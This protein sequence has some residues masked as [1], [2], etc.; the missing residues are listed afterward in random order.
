MKGACTEPDKWAQPGWKIEQK[1]GSK[2]M[3]GN[4]AEDRLQFTQEPEIA[5]S[6]SRVDF[7][8]HWDFKPDISERRSAL[9]R[10]EG[11]PSK[12]LFAHDGPAPSHYPVT[13][14]EDSY[15]RRHNNALPTLRPCHP[16]SLTWQLERSERPISVI[17]NMLLHTLVAVPGLS[18]NRG[19]SRAAVSANS[20]ALQST[21]HRLEKQ[22][23]RLPSLTVYRSAYQKH[24]LSAVCQSRSARTSRWLSSHL[25]A[26]NHNNKDL[27]LRRR[28]LLQVPD[29]CFG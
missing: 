19:H 29:H 9:L 4:W 21:K 11:L 25:H 7:R 12:L 26:A 14:Y 28:P 22:Q 17:L 13:Q 10:A 27:D 1:Y 2:V 24:P 8:P 23:S 20:G 3:V 15:G 16:G 6:T 18:D 5:N